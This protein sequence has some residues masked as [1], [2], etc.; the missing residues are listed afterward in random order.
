MISAARALSPSPRPSTMPQAIASTF[1]T[2]PPISR[3]AS[4]PATNT[5]GSA[6]CRARR[7]IR[8]ARSRVAAGDRRPRPAARAPP[9]RQSSAPTAPRPALRAMTSRVDFRHRFQRPGLDPLGAQQQRQ[10]AGQQRRQPGQARH[11]GIAPARRAA[12]LRRRRPPLGMSA[13]A[14]IAGSRDTPGS[15]SGFSWRRL[16]ASTTAGI[17]RPQ[18][19]T[20]RPARRRDGRQR[21]APGA[22]ADDRQ[23]L[24]RAAAVALRRWHWRRAASAAATGASSPSVSPRRNRS[25]P[26][27]AIIAPLS[28][29]SAGGGATKSSPAPLGQR[30][31]A[32]AQPLVGRDPAG[33]DEACPA[34]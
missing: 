30:G 34:G 14:T 1:L 10:R 31:E 6:R 9:R 12:P 33:G 25:I 29:H 4:G 17:A 23:P 20:D 11:A 13:V 26:A 15:S 32:R 8:C 21:G 7:Q 24:H 27:Q 5:A 22:A 2:A 18:R 3:P 28:V 16:I 19:D